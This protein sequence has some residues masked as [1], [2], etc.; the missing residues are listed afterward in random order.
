MIGPVTFEASLSRGQLLALSG[1]RDM[2]MRYALGLARWM[3]QAG[4]A[5]GRDD[6]S[7]ELQRE[8]PL[9]VIG[10]GECRACGAPAYTDDLGTYC[11]AGCAYWEAAA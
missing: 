11:T 5:D 4:Y 3:Y 10:V 1:E 6:L 7:R 9:D 8:D 2:W